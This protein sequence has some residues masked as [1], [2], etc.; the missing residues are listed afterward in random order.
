MKKLILIILT[1]ILLAGCGD[2]KSNLPYSISYDV[3]MVESFQFAFHYEKEEPEFEFLSPSG[4]FY[5]K[6]SEGLTIMRT[7]DPGQPNASVY[8][9]FDHG[10]I[11]EWK[12]YYDKFSNEEVDMFYDSFEVW[13]PN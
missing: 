5:N 1:L 12:I 4:K 9:I 11:G 6:D 2:A 3:D 13:H 10:E 8:Y 7:G